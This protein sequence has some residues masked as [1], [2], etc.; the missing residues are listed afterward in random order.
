MADDITLSRDWFMWA[1]DEAMWEAVSLH[2]DPARMVAWTARAA[3]SKTLGQDVQAYSP[4][5]AQG[6][7]TPAGAETR[8]GSVERSEIEP[9]PAGDAPVTRCNP[10]SPQ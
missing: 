4:I 2:G 7:V 5:Y 1:F 8:S 6:I 10:E 3:F 9:D